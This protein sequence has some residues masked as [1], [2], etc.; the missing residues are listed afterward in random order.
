MLRERLACLR[1][2]GQVLCRVKPPPPPFPLPFEPRR[3]S[4]R[5]PG[6]KMYDGSFTDVVS[7]VRLVN[8]L[9]RDFPCF[10]DEHAFDGRRRPVRL[11]K[12]AQILVA[13]LWAC[14][15]GESWGKFRDIDKIT[16]F[17]DYRVPQ[18]L[19][20]MGALYCCPSLSAAI[21]EKRLIEC[22]SAWEVQ[23]RGWIPPFPPSG[24]AASDGPQRAAYGA[25][26]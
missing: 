2:C 15:Q 9:A 20:S 8:L 13:D 12:R 1:E 22:G 7:A 26:S 10:R 25:S 11:L 21:R 6:L 24:N 18:I 5:A 17:A 23:L 3:R 14:F 4:D 19:I 16:I